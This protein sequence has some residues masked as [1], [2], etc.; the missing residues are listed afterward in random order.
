MHTTLT[1]PLA[2][3]PADILLEIAAYL[4]STSDVFHLS[5]SS[6]LLFA[7]LYSA[8]YAYVHLN[9]VTQ[10]TSTLAMLCR[11]PDIARHV[12]KLFISLG[13][14]S[15]TG[16]IGLI[17]GY[18][19]SSHLIKA[20]RTLDA[21][22][23]FVWD[24]DEIPP[25]DDVWWALR[26]NCP[27]L[28][29]IGASYGT[30]LPDP[31][32]HL[33]DFSG[34]IGFSLIS[35]HGMYHALETM[36]S[37]SRL[38]TMLIKRCPDLEEL[39]ID[40]A[41]F[42]PGTVHPLCH[43]RWPRLRRLGVGDIVLDWHRLRNNDTKRPFIEF[44]EAHPQLRSLRTSRHALNPAHMSDLDID[45]LPHLEEFTGSLEHLQVIAA[46]HPDIKHVTFNEPMII[47]DLAPMVIVNVLQNLHSLNT[48]DIS[49]AFHSTYESGSLVRSLVGACPNLVNFSLTCARKPSLQ[50][51][52]FSKA[53][54][55]LS[56]LRWL[57]LTLVRHN[58]EEPLLTCA[59]NIARSNPRLS[60]INI[61][62]IP[63][64]V[65][66]P[67]PLPTSFTHSPPE[68]HLPP[69]FVESGSYTL[70]TDEHGLPTALA[71]VERRATLPLLGID[72]SRTGWLA[73]VGGRILA[74]PRTRRFTVDLQPKKPWRGYGSLLVERSAAGEEV[75]LLTVLVSLASLSVWGYV[76]FGM[77]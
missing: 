49:F 70:S 21:L 3:L 38:W 1:S 62:F 59:I 2:S 77:G 31:H 51:E 20:A 52:N 57:N 69:D 26:N 35:K 73:Q 46:A 68:T 64:C 15:S 42:D 41:S 63:P 24:G 39:Y 36:S 25:Y 17:D 18:N 72:V 66:L 58:Y 75:R 44:L 76:G 50:L 14:E 48:L 4:N 11:R 61:N 33:Y 27:Q 13:H 30:L 45:A 22:N 10:C 40:G 16:Q 7:N 37:E 9:S 5:I 65:T 28:R 47:R 67:L 74:A 71:C 12:R 56:R 8:L 6:T 43:G 54:R 23:T 34:L 60:Y 53:I 55:P 29:T 19:V 32:S